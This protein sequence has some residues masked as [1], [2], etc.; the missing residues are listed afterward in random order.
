MGG[1]FSS[2]VNP[3]AQLRSPQPNCA[4]PERD[5]A[6]KVADVNLQSRAKPS[7]AKQAAV[8]KPLPGKAR[9]FSRVNTF[10]MPS[11]GSAAEDINEEDLAPLFSRLSSQKKE[12]DLQHFFSALRELGTDLEEEEIQRVFSNIDKD[13]SG[14]LDFTEFVY[15]IKHRKLLANLFTASNFTGEDFE[16]S[17]SY[18][19]SKTT[20]ENY[21]SHVPKDFDF[22]LASN[23]KQKLLC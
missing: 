1:C 7:Q 6:I 17:S 11:N 3:T 23:E 14:G 18:D 16:I 22:S 5:D 4:S 12:I 15:A 20:N 2:K 9:R 19:W 21:A 13:G 10:G 8:P